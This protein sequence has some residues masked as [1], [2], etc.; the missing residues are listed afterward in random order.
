ML[1]Y[2]DIVELLTL[3]AKAYELLMWLSRASVDD[4][5]LLSV[6]AAARLARPGT[7]AAWIAE[8]RAE[9]PAGLAPVDPQGPFANLLSSFFSTSFRVEHL[10]FKNR[11]VSARIVL[12][13]SPG[14]PDRTGIV[15]TQALAV[16]HLAS[17]QKLPTTEGQA[18]SLLRARRDLR[19][20]V[21]LWT[22]V[23]ELD[24]RARNRGKG[25]VVH[26][27]W[28]SIPWERKRALTAD[29]VWT[30]RQQLLDAARE[31]AGGGA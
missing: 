9:L 29:Q 2:D 5:G 15:R 20:A 23:W 31:H 3:H 1:G 10:E 7:A 28:R 25:P 6:D 21:L 16:K 14:P 4:P 22:Y 11:I 12:Y 13:A 18:R 17:S 8:H 19:D 30:A 26:Q 27:I 24:R